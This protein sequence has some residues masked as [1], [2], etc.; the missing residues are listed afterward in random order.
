MKLLA[1]SGILSWS[2][3]STLD[4]ISL[5]IKFAQGSTKEERQAV[6][7]AAERS[8]FT[9]ESVTIA[10]IEAEIAAAEA[11][12]NTPVGKTDD[13]HLFGGFPGEDQ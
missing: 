7:D 5:T 13:P 4:H 10:G 6:I 9:V 3:C 11:I 12:R 1:H 8:G 2:M